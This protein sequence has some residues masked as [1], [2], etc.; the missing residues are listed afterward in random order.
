MMVRRREKLFARG[1][2][3]AG[4]I[5]SFTLEESLDG[6]KSLRLTRS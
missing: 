6:P 2:P 3:G 1:E 4:V 5:E